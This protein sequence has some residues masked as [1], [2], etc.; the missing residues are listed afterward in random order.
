MRENRL[1]GSEG[2]ELEPNRAFLPLSFQRPIAFSTNH[3]TAFRFRSVERGRVFR[4]A[5]LE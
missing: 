5:V 4:E 2:G 1:S 3:E